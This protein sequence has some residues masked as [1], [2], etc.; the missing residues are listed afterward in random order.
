MIDTTSFLKKFDLFNGL[1]DVQLERVAAICQGVTYQAGE[2]VLEKN[3]P[4][5]E[6]YLI[7]SGAVEVIFSED[8]EGESRLPQVILGQ[9][10][11]FGEMALLDR[12]PRSATVRCAADDSE[13]YLYDRD[14]FLS[15]CEED[16]GIGYIVMRNMAA[17]LSFKLRH[18]QYLI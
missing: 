13:F 16:T 5:N 8:P 11:P 1:D 6:F 18:R 7:K 17:D 15:L 14:E 4:S 2:T 9:G 10:Q 3:S 12:G